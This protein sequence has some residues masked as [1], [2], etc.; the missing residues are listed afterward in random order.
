MNSLYRCDPRIV[1]G[2]AVEFT[3]SGNDE[4]NETCGHGRAELRDNGTKDKFA[5]KAAMKPTS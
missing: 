5:S 1:H 2:D 3:W 4:I